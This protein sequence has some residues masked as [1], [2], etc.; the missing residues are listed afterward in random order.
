M[1]KIWFARLKE[2]A[3]QKLGESLKWKDSPGGGGEYVHK[4]SSIATLSNGW[5][6]SVIPTCINQIALVSPSM[7]TTLTLDRYLSQE[8]KQ[9]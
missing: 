4:T 5:T 7:G 1:A 6:V 8:G 2:L 9:Q 3:E